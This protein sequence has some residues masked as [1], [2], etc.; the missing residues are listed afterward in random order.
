MD[1]TVYLRALE[2]SDIEKCH[3]WHNDDGL[4]DTLV[5]PFRF[6]SKQAEQGW[7]ERKAAFSL[8]EINLAICLKGSD[9][10]IGNIYLREIDWISRRGHLSIFIGESGK[11][12]KGYGQS[13]IRLLISYGFK[14]LGLKKIF[15]Y[16]LEDNKAAIHVYEKC[17]FN[18]EG[19]LKNHVFQRG[20]FKNL[21]VMGICSNDVDVAHN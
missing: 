5:G 6:V 11:S 19:L 14:D 3:K 21:I 13:A 7:I 16:V 18:I 20:A 8:N 12:S 10:H 17:G 15:L 4:Y 1:K 2:A 9:K